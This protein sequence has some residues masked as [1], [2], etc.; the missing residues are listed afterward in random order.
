M[1]FWTTNFMNKM[2][3]EW[4]RRIGKIQYQDNNGTWY[5]DQSRKNS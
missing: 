3:N 5:D 2:R 4:L 1:A